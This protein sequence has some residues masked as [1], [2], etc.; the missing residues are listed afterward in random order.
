MSLR[1]IPILSLFLSDL[2]TIAMAVVGSRLR[3]QGFL[4]PT[5]FCLSRHNQQTHHWSYNGNHGKMGIF[6]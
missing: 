4:D 3:I 6:F 2:E 1:N 5:Y